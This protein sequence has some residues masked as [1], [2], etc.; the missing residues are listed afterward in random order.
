MPANK[1]RR[2]LFAPRCWRKTHQLVFGA[3][4]CVNTFS[5]SHNTLS[6]SAFCIL[7]VDNICHQV[8]SSPLSVGSMRGQLMRGWLVQSCSSRSRRRKYSGSRPTW[9]AGCPGQ[10]SIP[11]MTHWRHL[12]PQCL[13]FETPSTLLLCPIASPR[14]VSSH[15]NTII[16]LKKFS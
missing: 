11:Q 2:A 4:L 5:Q 14:S 9:P 13:T 16:S 8:S 10:T 7:W 15:F 12:T 1:L 6:N 3:F